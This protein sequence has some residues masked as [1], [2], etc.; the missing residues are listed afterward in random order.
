MELLKK[1]AVEM[2]KALLAKEVSAVEL[3]NET[4]KRVDD[5]EEKIGAF[6]SLTKE[7]A[8]N[9]A[10]EVDKKIAAGEELPKMAGIPLALKDNINLKGYKTTASSKILENFI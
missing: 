9:V 3:V 1:T 7:Y 2:R 4:Y 8:L 5:V 6:N 10:N